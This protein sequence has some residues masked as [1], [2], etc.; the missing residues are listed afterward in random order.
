MAPSGVNNSARAMMGAIRRNYDQIIAGS[1][2]LPYLP[3][4]GGTVTGDINATGNISTTGA[5]ICNGGNING[6][7]SVTNAIN[8]GGNIAG[9][10]LTGDLLA[11]NGNITAVGT[12]TGAAVNSNGNLGVAGYGTIA[13]NLTVGG[14]VN[15]TTVA[16]TGT[17]SG[18]LVTANSISSNTTVNAAQY[19]LRGVPFAAMD[20]GAVQ[21]IIYSPA[22]Q[23]ITLVASG[24]NYYDT[25]NHVFR[26]APSGGTTYAVFN[27]GGSYNQTGSWGVI[28]DAALKTDI[29]DYNERGLSEI[30]SLRPVSFRYSGGPFAGAETRYGLIAQ[31]VARIVPEMVGEEV[32][33]DDRVLTMQPGHLIWLLIRSCQELAA[34]VEALEGGAR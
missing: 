11:S 28:S 29:R 26:S 1:L 10:I 19:N 34:R 24:T 23:N 31:E 16:A 30:K 21:T 3:I 18:N 25:F 7:L 6:N 12:I 15:A 17:V 4:T 14:T 33:G 27:A 22:A 8:A 9:N 13:I 2:S 5:L 32:F 20:A